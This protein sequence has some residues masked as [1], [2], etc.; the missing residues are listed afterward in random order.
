MNVLRMVYKTEDRGFTDLKTSFLPLLSRRSA[1]ARAAKMR[2]LINTALEHFQ[3]HADSYRTLTH[4][5]ENGASC[6]AS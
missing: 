5:L 1:L 4:S 2:L 3:Y 6:S